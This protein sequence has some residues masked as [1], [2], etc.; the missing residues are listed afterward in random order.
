MTEDI[1]RR[2]FL[3]NISTA[4]L[5]GL[6]PAAAFA[7]P[8][9]EALPGADA[10]EGLPEGPNTFLTAPYLQ[11]LSVDSVNIMWINSRRSFNWVELYEEGKPPRKF[12]SEK[13]GL[14]Q[15][16]NRINNIPLEGLKP[17]T[18]Y[19]Y[20]VV[21]TEITV[22]K[23]YSITFGETIEQGPFEFKTLSGEEKEVRFAVFNDLH[24]R[25]Q[26]ISELLGKLAPEKDY[27]F[28]VYNGDSFNW[29][30]DEPMIIKNLL[31][32]SASLFASSTPFIMVQGNHEP[33]GKYARQ[34]FD[35]FNYPGGNCYFA[36]SQGP[37]RFV[38]LDSG[39]DK[40]DSSEEYSGLVSYDRY[41]EKQARWLEKEIE[42]REF[43]KAA[44]R[45]ALIHISP[46]HSGDWHGT[47]H[48][49]KVFGPLMNKGKFDLQLSGHTHRYKTH[50]ANEDH[51]FP[52]M[53]G[54][55][56]G[57]EGRGV[58]TLIKGRAGNEELHVQML[59]DDGSIAGEYRLT[60]R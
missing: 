32:P 11:H 34:M 40:E 20:K 41:R 16:N 46:W 48:C 29:V 39:E 59:L 52:I 57:F 28:V 60:Q 19:Q 35:Y 15:A 54:G 2:D 53:I 30:D 58:R 21:S 9:A 31:E 45:V 51:H 5:L 1:K 33:R 49:R 42:S 14:I 38:V 26:N 22:F 18:P 43:K 50:D 44:F 12:F 17:G 7:V 36:F 13:N 8:A 6:M 23:P 47:L 56:P 4:G 3:K 24:E 10:P 25:P 55:G 37:V 27:D